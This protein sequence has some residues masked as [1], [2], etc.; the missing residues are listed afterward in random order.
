MSFLQK[1]PET[2]C[3]NRLPLGNNGIDITFDSFL[4]ENLGFFY[5]RLK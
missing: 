3:R 5:L 4:N 2:F 1:T